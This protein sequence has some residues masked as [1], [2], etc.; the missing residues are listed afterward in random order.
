MPDASGLLEDIR[1]V[2]WHQEEPF[3][4]AG[5]FAQ[6]RVHCLAREKG[7]KVLI[8]GQGADEVF[9]GYARYTHWHLQQRLAAFE[10]RDAESEARLLHASGFL[11]DW[12][13]QHRIAAFLPALTA[14]RLEARAARRHDTDP[15]ISPRFRERASGAGFIHKPVVRTLNDILYH[16]ACQGPLQELLRYADRNAMSQGVEVRLP[17]LDHELAQFLFSLPNRYKYRDGFTKWVLRRAYQERITE[18]IAWRKG[19]TGFEPPQLDWMRDPRVA[20]EVRKGQERLVEAGM[21]S[22]SV[23]KRAVVPCAAYAPDTRDWRHWVASLFL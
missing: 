1:T 5:I 2:A 11:P 21:L 8:D 19:K 7:V 10:M 15:D 9:A 12:G 14:S 17:Y 16:D 4:T 18:T 3:T 13:W 23:L 20:A 22:P 6:Y